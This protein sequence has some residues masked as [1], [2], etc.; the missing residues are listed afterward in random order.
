MAKANQTVV[1]EIIAVTGQVEGAHHAIHGRADYQYNDPMVRGWSRG[2]SALLYCERSW[3]HVGGA[4]WTWKCY[5][6]V[7]G[8]AVGLRLWASWNS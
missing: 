6:K 7:N 5:Y 8:R 2:D 3:R 4:Y 1:M